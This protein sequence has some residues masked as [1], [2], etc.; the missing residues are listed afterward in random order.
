MGKGQVLGALSTIGDA[1][2]R[3][4]AR[5]YRDEAYALLFAA[6]GEVVGY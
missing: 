5:I 1:R 6:L 3:P 2:F 4:V